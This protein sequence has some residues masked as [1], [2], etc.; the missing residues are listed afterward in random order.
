MSLAHYCADVNYDA[1]AGADCD[2]DA[3]VVAA[4]LYVDGPEW[5]RLALSSKLN[6]AENRKRIKYENFEI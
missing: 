2:A 6:S 1:D 4:I 5:K 3:D